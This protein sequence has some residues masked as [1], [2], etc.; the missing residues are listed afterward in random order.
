MLTLLIVF[1]LSGVIALVDGAEACDGLRTGTGDYGYMTTD[2]N[3]P[4]NWGSLK[5]E[6]E[7]CATGKEQS[8]FNLETI[9]VSLPQPAAERPSIV[10]RRS[11]VKYE[12]TPKNFQFTCTRSDFTCGKI[13]YEGKTYRF[14]QFH[15]HYL[16]EY[17][18]DDVAYPIDGHLV[19]IADDGSLLVLGVFFKYGDHHHEFQKLLDAAKDRG[20]REVYFHEFYDPSSQLVVFKGSLTTPPCAE[21]VQWLVSTT[22]LTFSPEQ[23]AAFSCMLGNKPNNRPLEKANGR[24]MFVFPATD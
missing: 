21:G 5:M 15:L 8:P 16:S 4:P 10:L 17:H 18:L 1:V 14:L 9:N 2:P 7:V 3:G 19:H 12:G 20:E 6:Y 24:P 22:P 23:I 13:V 11:F